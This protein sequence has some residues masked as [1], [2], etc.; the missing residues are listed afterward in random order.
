MTHTDIS[1]SKGSRARPVL[2]ILIHPKVE[3]AEK[4]VL[5]SW[6]Y[7]ISYSFLPSP[8]S[9][10]RKTKIGRKLFEKNEAG[11]ARFPAEGK[12]C[13]HQIY[14]SAKKETKQRTVTNKG[15]VLRSY[16][17]MC[18]KQVCFRFL[19]CETEVPTSNIRYWVDYAFYEEKRVN[20]A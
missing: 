11:S 18:A 4:N 7:S 16:F 17:L 1:P 3:Y 6:K 9:G 13:V 5:L 19:F 8:L 14:F 15:N 10:V 12:V 20:S 2:V